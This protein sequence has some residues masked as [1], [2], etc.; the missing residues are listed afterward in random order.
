MYSICVKYDR[1][2]KP[3]VLFLIC[4]HLISFSYFLLLKLRKFTYKN[5][6]RIVVSVCGR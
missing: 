1:K 6:F 2:E 4:T 3:V 5:I